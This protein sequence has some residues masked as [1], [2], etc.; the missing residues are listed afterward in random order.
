M[1][2]KT[3]TV[4]WLRAM[5]IRALRTAAQ[6]ALG[7]IGTSTYI[8]QLD[9]K[10]ILSMVALATLTSVLTSIVTELPEV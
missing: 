1:Q 9:V 3:N 8:T 2:I 6:V 5:G 10:T 7:A 4:K